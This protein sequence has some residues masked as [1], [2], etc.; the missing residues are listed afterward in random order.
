MHV[1]RSLLRDA[2]AGGSCRVAADEHKQGQAQSD[3]G[4]QQTNRAA[5]ASATMTT[6][7]FGMAQG[8]ANPPS[9]V[10]RPVNAEDWRQS[11]AANLRC[12]HDLGDRTRIAIY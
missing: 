7:G 10:I 4:G 3:R 9:A 2:S 5:N 11:S 1:C 12:D 8:S 6:V